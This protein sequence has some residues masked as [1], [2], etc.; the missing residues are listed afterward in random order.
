MA[1]T[2]SSP[3]PPLHTIGRRRLAA[4]FRR[5]SRARVTLCVAPAGYGKTTALNQF[6][7]RNARNVARVT[8][9]CRTAGL[10]NVVREIASE[11]S[12]VLMRPELTLSAVFDRVAVSET[13]ELDLARWLQ[14]HLPDHDVELVIDDLDAVAAD[15]QVVRFLDRVIRD[16]P[17][18]RW[19][20]LTRNSGSLPL[21]NWMA[22]GLLD[23]PLDQHSL[24]FTDEETLALSRR[25]EVLTA[26]QARDLTASMHGW[27]LGIAVRLRHG[28]RFGDLVYDRR[29]TAGAYRAL[30]DACYRRC[31][32][33]ERDLLLDTALMQRLH[34]AAVRA[35]GWRDGGKL[36]RRLQTQFPHFFNASS[37][38]L[39]YDDL[40]RA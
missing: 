25:Y 18:L 4:L 20:L 35:L 38:S 17:Q 14:S 29:N 11:L 12:R 9:S 34:P 15:A 7:G 8:L 16:A 28:A 13:P 5:A 27:P 19:Y 6:L 31:S 40:T 24:A 37:G 2:G 33:R 39:A 22:D 23:L 26:V 30:L 1:S 36:L 32:E 3:A 21:P 10:F